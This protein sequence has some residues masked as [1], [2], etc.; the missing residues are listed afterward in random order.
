MADTPAFD[1][2]K[3]AWSLTWDADWVTAVSFVG[4]SRRL[5]AGNNLGDILLWELPE[6]ADAAAPLPARR[7]AG[8][9]N[10]VNRL[11]AS[12]D[13]NRLFSCSHD[14]TIR[15]WDMK[16]EAKGE[17]KLVLNASARE[18]AITRKGS[19]LKV[20]TPIEA[21][22]AKQSAQSEYKGHRDWVLG[23]AMSRDEKILASGD[24]GG[25]VLVRDA[26]SGKEINR[27]QLKGWAYAVALSPDAKKVL[28]S[29]RVP[30][31]F[32]SGRQDAV[33]VWD[34]ESAKPVLDLAGTFKGIY[35]C[36]AS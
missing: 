5:V 11:I 17:E 24:D 1:K 18:R 2:A 30:L 26:A 35:L 34:R 14:H 16:A 22:V 8:H 25:L 33:K 15:V 9:S 3:L 29:E 20:P 32:D 4:S 27:W 23:M 19:G 13:G 21:K 31:V 36:A 12:K 10:A 7:L 6:K 28:V